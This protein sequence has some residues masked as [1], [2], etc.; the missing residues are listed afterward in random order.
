M[1][2][3]DDPCSPYEPTEM[4]SPEVK[5][6]PGQA[7][8]PQVKVRLIEQRVNTHKFLCHGNIISTD[9]SIHYVLQCGYDVA[10][11]SILTYIGLILSEGGGCKFNIVK[12]MG[13]RVSYRL[14]LCHDH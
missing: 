8:V 3:G 5:Q 11:Y 13:Q 9:K 10:K 2:Q 14:S 4:L 12:K 6:R 7:Q 1:L